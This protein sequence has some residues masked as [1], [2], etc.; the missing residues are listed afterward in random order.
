MGIFCNPQK[1]MKLMPFSDGTP[2]QHKMMPQKD[3]YQS[4]KGLAGFK[5]YFACVLI[6]ILTKFSVNPYYV[7]LSRFMIISTSLPS[8][9]LLVQCSIA[10]SNCVTHDILGWKP[11]CYSKTIGWYQIE[12]SCLITDSNILQNTEVKLIGL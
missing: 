2:K 7:P 6:G 12:L 1:I 3:F 9:K 4:L 5:A 8:S 10:C 11:C